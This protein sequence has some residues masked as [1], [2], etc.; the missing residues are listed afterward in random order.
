MNRFGTSDSPN[1]NSIQ[2]L[3]LRDYLDILRR[4][5]TWILLTALGIFVMG[6]VVAA[7]LPNVYHSETVIVVDPQQVSDSLVAS[8]TASSVLDRLSTIRQLVM[9]PTRL[10]D[11]IQKL[12]LYPGVKDQRDME[13]V[14]AGMQRQIN[15]EVADAGTQRLSAFKIGF[16]SR[17]P[18]QAADVANTLAAMVIEESLKAREHQLSGAEQF[19]DTELESTKKQLEDK[20][21]EVSRIKSQYIM[22]IPDSKQFHLEALDSLRSQLRSSQDRVSRDQTE[23]VYLQSMLANSSPAVDLDANRGEGAPSQTETQI[24]KAETDLAELRSRYG[25]DY[26]DVRKVQSQLQALKAKK[27]AEDENA[28]KRELLT[29]SAPKGVKNPVVTSQ[30]AKLDQDIIDQNKLQAQLNDQINFHVSNLEQVPIFES[31]IAGMMRDYDSLRAHY[32]ALLDRKISA[33][34]ASNLENHQKAERFTTLDVARV[35][36]E[37]SAPNRPFIALGALFAGLF[38]GIGVAVVV[39]LSDTAVRSEKEASRILAAPVLGGIPIIVSQSQLVLRKARLVAAIAATIV[40]SAGV[41]LIITF[42]TGWIG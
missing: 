6:L 13:S 2:E 11:V 34:M 28:P 22:V 35:P 5:K 32:N 24:E 23:K 19:I 10:A 40:G 27:A 29:Q 38:V 26:P 30:L 20:E 39:D 14:I 4:R 12:N 16:T 18:K 25:S 37:P 1:D 15:I 21:A 7:R 8:S 31:K 3:Q 9:S 41:G 33:G 42:V 17:S 36:D